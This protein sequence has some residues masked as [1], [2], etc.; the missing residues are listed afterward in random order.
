M[1][2]TLCMKLMPIITRRTFNCQVVPSLALLGYCKVIV[3]LLL[4]LCQVLSEDGIL[5]TVFSHL[6]KYIANNNDTKDSIKVHTDPKKIYNKI[7]GNTVTR[8]PSLLST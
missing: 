6:L 1:F 5:V 8:I 7:T 4:G 2:L 3:R